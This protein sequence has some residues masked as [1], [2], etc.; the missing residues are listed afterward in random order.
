MYIYFI[1]TGLKKI[2]FIL[3]KTIAIIPAAA[4]TLPAGI[5]LKQLDSVAQSNGPGRGFAGLYVK[6]T[7]EIERQLVKMD[8][9]SITQIRRLEKNFAG[10]FINACKKL[11]ETNDTAAIWH[12]YFKNSG[13][14]DLKQKLLGI[15]AHING[16]L[17]QALRDSYGKEEIKEAG[18]TVFLFHQSLLKV[19]N[20]LYTEAKTGNK[21]IKTFHVLS[22]GFGEAYGRHLLKKWRK[23][24][25]KLAML[26]YF[27]QKKFERLKTKTERKKYKIDKMINRHLK[28]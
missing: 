9:V 15:N 17:W 12:A 8:S 10:Y 25:I 6:T 23:R 5:V 22:L 24:Q 7:I 2:L 26:Y 27:N 14:S 11:S 28:G 21:K 1:K 4:Q 19:Y 20:D 3:F 13:S 16:D 18:I